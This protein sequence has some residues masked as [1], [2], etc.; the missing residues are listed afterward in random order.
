MNCD[1][2]DCLVLNE[3]CM[4]AGPEKVCAEPLKGSQHSLVND[5]I[6]FS[7]PRQLLLSANVN[8]SCD[9]RTSDQFSRLQNC[10]LKEVDFPN[11]ECFFFTHTYKSCEQSFRSNDHRS[12]LLAVRCVL[13]RL[14]HLG[15]S[16]V[17]FALCRESVSLFH[18]DRPARLRNISKLANASEEQTRE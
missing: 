15:T 1:V 14:T 8:H 16:D 10:S 2:V 7:P 13:L 6:P 17:I 5:L 4:S 9:T 12:S 18:P 11:S 3:Y